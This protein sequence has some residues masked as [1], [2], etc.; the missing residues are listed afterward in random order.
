MAYVYRHIRLDKNQ[1]FYIGIGSDSKYNRAYSKNNR[2]N[3]W[4]NIVNKFD[5]RVDI[6]MDDLTWEEACDKEIELIELYGR[7]DLNLGTLVNLT[8]GGDGMSGINMTKETLI[9]YSECKIGN[10]NA[11]SVPVMNTLN[12]VYYDSIKEA[13]ESIG[14]SKYSLYKKLEGKRKNNTRFI[15]A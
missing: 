13:A 6:I 12:G 5:Y 8:N 15:L 3:Y 10:K 4:N 1:P 14:T 11:M 9:K 2:N 7:I